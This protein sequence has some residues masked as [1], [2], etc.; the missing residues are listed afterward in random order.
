[1]KKFLLFMSILLVV[2]FVQAQTTNAVNLTPSASQTVL[3]PPGTQLNINIGCLGTDARNVRGCFGAKGDMNTGGPCSMSASGVTLV[4][5]GGG[6]VS[7]DVGKDLY[8]QG[9]GAAGASLV[10]KVAAFTN[11][12]TILAANPASTTVSAAGIVWGTDDTTAIQ[13]ALNA[14]KAGGGAIYFPSG[15]Y[16][17]HGLNITGQSAKI[18]GDSYGSTQLYAIAVTNPGRIH[19]NWTVGVDISGSQYDQFTGLAFMGS[20]SFLADL[21]PQINVF[22]AR[23][24]MAGGD[25]FA[26]A[27]IFNEDFFSTSGAYDVVLYGYEQTDFR[28]CDFENVGSDNLGLLYLS[29]NNTPGFVSPYKNVVAP[30]NSMTKVSVSGARSVFAAGNGNFVVFDQG[31]SAGDYAISI[32]DAYIAFNGASGTFLSDTGTSTSFGLRNITLDQLYA[33]TPN[34]CRA[35]SMVNIGAPAWDWSIKNTQFY[36]G[37]SG[38]TVIP[39]TF[40]S[41]FF[42]GEVMIDSTGSSSGIEFSAP[43]CLG[44]DLHLGAQEPVTNCTDYHS[45]SGTSGVQAEN[46]VGQFQGTFSSS[47]AW[48]KLGT[49]A[50]ANTGAGPTIIF[51]TGAGTNS[52]SNQQNTAILAMRTGNGTVAPNLSGITITNL[53]TSGAFLGVKAVATG[54]SVL[55]TN[56]S[57]DIY[58]N[59]APSSLSTYQVILPVGTRWIP[60]NSASTDPGPASST[61]VVGNIQT[62][63]LGFIGSTGALPGTAIRAGTCVILTASIP[64]INSSMTVTATPQSTTQLI[65][66]L[67]WDTAYVSAL[68]TATIPVCNTTA[69]PITP[70]ITPTFNV[71]V[72]Q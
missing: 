72:I 62:T 64:G 12:T 50:G 1:M 61:V 63:L 29:S 25:D 16:L 71:R 45:A 33:E 59:Q 20:L 15:N 68:G 13:N 31:Q 40:S 3:Q 6:F 14:Q 46:V 57:W 34:N 23:T 55:G 67:H 39:Y 9:A 8:I 48:T 66:G 35:C 36:A 19:S 32:R 60:L 5:G 47:T 18:Y 49:Y 51:S 17:H 54:G 52:G 56:Q 10:T 37:G 41:G 7:A 27:H 30:I 53:N 28:N 65:A 21:A 44:S 24:G 42:D 70:N 11:A 22:G 26:I 69:S 58:L 2:G 4:C 43:T 38:L